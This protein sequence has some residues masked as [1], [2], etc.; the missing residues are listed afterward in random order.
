[1]SSQ[2]QIFVASSQEAKKIAERLVEELSGD[3][4]PVPWWTAFTLGEYTFEDLARKSI[5]SHAQ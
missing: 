3:F 1:M 2:K 4:L 5:T